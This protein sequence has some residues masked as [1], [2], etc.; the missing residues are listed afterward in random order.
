MEYAEHDCGRRLSEG[1]HVG[2]FIMQLAEVEVFCGWTENFVQVGQPVDW[3]QVKD[4]LNRSKLTTMR[5]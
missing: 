2:F 1:N 3:V 4:E 5:G